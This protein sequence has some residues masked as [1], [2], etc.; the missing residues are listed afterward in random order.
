ML[1]ERVLWDG[2][3]LTFK[4]II[5]DIVM[6]S[7]P[8]KIGT[9]IPIRLGMVIREAIAIRDIEILV[10]SPSGIQNHY[11]LEPAT[12]RYDE[13]IFDFSLA[14]LDVQE[15]GVHTIDVIVDDVPVA[16]RMLNVRLAPHLSAMH[17]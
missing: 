9:S 15:S 17:A 3:R 8:S 10:S 16:R 14:D 13:Q 1:C 11:R 2:E 7:V 6:R 4:G 5:D 12:V